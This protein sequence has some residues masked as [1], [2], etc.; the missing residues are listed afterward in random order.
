MLLANRTKEKNQVKDAVVEILTNECNK[1]HLTIAP[2]TGHTLKFIIKSLNNLIHRINQ[3]LYGRRY[4]KKGLHITGIVIMEHF[5]KSNP[6]FH[7]IIRD[8][9]GD[10]ES[11]CR[12]E[13]VLI[14]AIP[15]IGERFRVDPDDIIP[16]LISPNCWK[17][18]KYWND[19]E[20]SLEHY[21]SKEFW[22]SD[23]WTL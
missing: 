13:D 15:K 2:K 10:L 12:L 4:R 22:G 17:L 23:A 16:P 14:Q 5:D 21:L 3:K 7:I 8:P 9:R 19:G 11:R 18:Q 20:G 6:H 1:Y